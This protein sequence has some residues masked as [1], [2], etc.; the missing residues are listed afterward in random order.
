MKQVYLGIAMSLLSLCAGGVSKASVSPCECTHLRS[1]GGR[2]ICE[3]L[4]N[5]IRDTLPQGSIILELG[6]GWASG[7]LAKYYTLWSIEH[8]E[9]F[10]GLYKTNYI[11][12]P[13]INGWY[14]VDIL[15]EKLPTGYNLILVDGPPGHVGLG[16]LPFFT[17]L[18]LFEKDVP[19]IFDDVNRPAEEKL[20]ALVAHAL[21]RK[22]FV[23][24]C[25]PKKFGVVLKAANG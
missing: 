6:S 19:I 4:F 18:N 7:E 23:F 15:K 9:K 5:Y 11:Y 22:I 12:A 3:K 10:V 16:R 21:Q 14:N 17:H 20:M 13:L 25:G 2:S 24:E 8:D 1:F